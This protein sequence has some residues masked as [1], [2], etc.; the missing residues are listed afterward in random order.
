MSVGENLTDS[1]PT[2]SQNQ[3]V[4]S[5]RFDTVGARK[6]GSLTSRNVGNRIAI[7]LDGVVISAPECKRTHYGGEWHYHR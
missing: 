6:F 3:P 2:Y 5:F 4:V 1:Q 7:L